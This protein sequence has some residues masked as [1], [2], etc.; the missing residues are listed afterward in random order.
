MK[1]LVLQ[2][3]DQLKRRLDALAAH[4]RKPLSDWAAEELG[5]LAANANENDP[6]TTY[7]AE[8]MDSFGSISDPAFDAPERPLPRPV[9]PVDTDA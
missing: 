2:I 6:I 5:R 3:D 9:Q 4:K 8:W 1:T 7:S